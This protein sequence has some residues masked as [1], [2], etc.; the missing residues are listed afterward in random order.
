MQNSK[1]RN[2]KVP[3]DPWITAAYQ[4]DGIRLNDGWW[5][6]GT[7]DT[8][9]L[10]QILYMY[11]TTPLFVLGLFMASI[12]IVVVAS[13]L[14][15]IIKCA[16]ALWNATPQT[17]KSEVV[18]QVL[19]LMDPP[20]STYLRTRYSSPLHKMCYISFHANFM[21]V[22][23][24]SEFAAATAFSSDQNDD[25]IEQKMD[26]ETADVMKERV[27]KSTRGG[28]DSRNVTFMVWLFD[29]GDQYRHLI[30]PSIIPS[31]EAAHERDKQR[32]TKKNKPSKKRDYLR[33]VCTATL[34]AID[35][36]DESTIPIKLGILEFK[37]FTRFLST[38]KKTIKK[39]KIAQDGEDVVVN[40][41]ETEIRLSPSSYDGACS[42]LSS[43]VKL[44]C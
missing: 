34:K 29:K 33:N 25:E 18:R 3:N 41:S 11:F 32:R 28:Y 16:A 23:S 7:E 15:C 9:M 12:G 26:R 1:P 8:T 5:L 35:P 21:W 17:F 4:N 43:C 31:M 27:A 38:F 42:A 36:S 22:S 2:K 30:E 44:D 20:S 13:P 37:I 24:G 14:A 10:F 19:P 39:R 6:D 40:E